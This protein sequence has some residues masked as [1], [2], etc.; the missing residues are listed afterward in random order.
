MPNIKLSMKF[1]KPK[2]KKL[3]PVCRNVVYV[4]NMTYCSG[5]CFGKA[6]QKLARRSVNQT[7]KVKEN[8]VDI[9]SDPYLHDYQVVQ[10]LYNEYR[11]HGQLIVA[12]DYDGTVNDYH[13]SG[14]RYNK[15]IELLRRARAIGFYLIVFTCSGE[16][17]YPEIIDNLNKANVPFDLINENHPAITFAQNKIYYDI[18]LD[19]RAGLLSAYN[20]LEKVISIIEQERKGEI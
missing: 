3:C 5:E 4:D 8:A 17:R 7:K 2:P 10:R 11:I 18:L 14:H 9:L 16:E 15:V 1:F 12:F 19:D 6:M 20:N 13:N